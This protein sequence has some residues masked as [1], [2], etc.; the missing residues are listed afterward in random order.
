M[1]QPGSL[2]DLVK[3]GNNRFRSLGPVRPVPPNERQIRQGYLEM[4]GA[5]AT[6]QMM[7][8]IETSR[9]FEANTRMVQN[10]D[11]MTSSLISRVLQ[12]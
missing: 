6:D 4:S 7:A 1:M 8:M 9:A 3:V 2:G 12:R 11:S 10:H 5:N